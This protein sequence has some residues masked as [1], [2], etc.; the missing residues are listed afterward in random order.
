M[1]L[2]PYEHLLTNTS[3]NLR[4]DINQL[5][6]FIFQIYTLDAVEFYRRLK[7]VIDMSNTHEQTSLWILTQEANTVINAAK[8]DL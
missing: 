4:R 5:R 2:E 1:K 6:E 8:K 3:R 7:H